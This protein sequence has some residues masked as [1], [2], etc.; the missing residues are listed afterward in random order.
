MKIKVGKLV[1]TCLLMMFYMSS[2]E[3]KIS[4]DGYVI[5]GNVEG[6]E[7]GWVKIEENN[8]AERGG[9]RKVIDSVPIINGRFEA[10]GK[11]EHPDVVTL[12]VNDKSYSSFFI[13]NSPI[14]LELDL[15]TK[16][17]SSGSFETKVSGSK[18]HKIYQAQLEKEDSIRLQEKYNPLLELRDDREIAYKS[19]DESLIDAYK[20]KNEK[21]QDL[22]SQQY[23][24]YRNSKF[25]FVNKNPSS[26]VSPNV[27]GFQFS[28]GR[29]T[30]DQLK[31]FY[32]IFKGDAKNTAMFAYYKKTYTEVFESLGVG[33]I[34]PDF[35]LK[36]IVGDDIKL[37]DVDA[38]YKMVDFWASW[39][40][41]CRA[42]FP[43]L[44]DLRAKY[45]K[46]GFEILGVG[47]ADIQA[48]WE[49]A[50]EE[51]KIVW[52]NVFDIAPESEGRADYGAVAKMYSVPFLPTTFLMDGNQKIILRNPSKEELDKKLEEFYGY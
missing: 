31:K 44:K 32:S 25:V 48:K 1:L 36:N 29:M 47:T 45:S 28:E 49:K 14:I 20:E 35:T 41:P 17:K 40:V 12:N 15:T 6:V 22:L 50:I 9:K 52:I 39:C 42:S 34:A 33:A 38:N 10:K 7:S 23:E 18:Y 37:S 30:N 46:D 19:K 8:Y 5:S 26:P 4:H 16:G 3:N 21:L 43:H 11:V 27:L 2:C 51:D 13:E 24:E